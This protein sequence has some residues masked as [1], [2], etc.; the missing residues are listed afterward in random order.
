MKLDITFNEFISE[1]PVGEIGRTTKSDAEAHITPE[2]QAEFEK[3][4]KAIGGKAV[5]RA[6]LDGKPENGEISEAAKD[7]LAT[8]QKTLKKAGFTVKKVSSQ[9]IRYESDITDFNKFED[10]AIGKIFGGPIIQDKVHK[11]YFKDF[12]GDWEIQIWG[13]GMEE[14][15][16]DPKK[17]KGPF[18]GF[19]RMTYDAYKRE[20]A[21]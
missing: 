2:L 1:S 5:A 9:E 13:K 20:E 12:S 3:V 18:T 8:M 21:K 4:V 11:A 6:L 16:E 10:I 19:V 17:F 7:Y 15:T 14:N